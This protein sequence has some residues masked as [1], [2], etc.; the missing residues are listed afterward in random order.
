MTLHLKPY[1]EGINE[2]RSMEAYDGYLYVG[3]MKIGEHTIV[4]DIYEEEIDKNTVEL[5]SVWMDPEEV[6][7]SQI[8]EWVDRYKANMRNFISQLSDCGYDTDDI[9]IE[10]D[11]SQGFMDIYL[12]NGQKMTVIRD[13]FDEEYLTI[14][15]ST[16]H[17]V[18]NEIE[19]QLTRN[20]YLNADFERN[21]Q[22]R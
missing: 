22:G 4:Y 5:S 11:S 19:K 21:R 2:S 20:F 16:D 18:P 12:A 3:E 6:G 17:I 10:E 15:L 1:L 9:K 7:R 8:A 13:E 14:H